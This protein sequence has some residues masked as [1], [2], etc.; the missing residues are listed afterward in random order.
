MGSSSA[1]YAQKISHIKNTSTVS[2]SISIILIL[3]SP[4]S[5]EDSDQFEIKITHEKNCVLSDIVGRK[6]RKKLLSN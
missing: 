5:I 3:I 4:F 2:G 1:L 6:F